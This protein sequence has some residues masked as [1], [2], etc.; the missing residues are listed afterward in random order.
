LSISYHYSTCLS[1]MFSISFHN[2]LLYFPNLI[3]IQLGFLHMYMS[4]YRVMTPHYPPHKE[5]FPSYSVIPP[6]TGL[7]PLLQCYPHMNSYVPYC[8]VK[9]PHKEL[10][11]LL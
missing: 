10:F 1:S 2:F 9:P 3:T 11:P 5:L 7:C 8:N 4:K 6:H